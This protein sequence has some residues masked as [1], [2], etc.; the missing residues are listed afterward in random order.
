MNSGRVE[1]VTNEE[2]E[3]GGT[4]YLLHPLQVKTNLT[5]DPFALQTLLPNQFDLSRAD[6]G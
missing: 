4:I 3:V 1:V 6:I 2:K 5:R